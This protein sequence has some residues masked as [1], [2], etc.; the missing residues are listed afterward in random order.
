MLVANLAKDLHLEAGWGGL[1]LPDGRFI[2]V[3]TSR[4]SYEIRKKEL[5]ITSTLGEGFKGHLTDSTGTYYPR[6]VVQFSTPILNVPLDDCIC[7]LIAGEKYHRFDIPR[8]QDGEGNIVPVQVGAVYT[9]KCDG[10]AR[11][12]DN[13]L[14]PCLCIKIYPPGVEGM[15]SALLDG[16]P[17]NWGV[18]VPVQPEPPALNEG[19]PSITQQTNPSALE[20]GRQLQQINLGG[21]PSTAP[22]TGN[23]QWSACLIQD[24]AP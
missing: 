24:L 14:I 8:D 21:G 23:C 22:A 5:R 9:I 4:S 16:D 18:A 6:I 17:T 13:G 3:I 7:E 2:K 20:V 15:E 19:N 12:Y 10:R 11:K 1:V